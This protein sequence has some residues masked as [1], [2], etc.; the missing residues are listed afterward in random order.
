M[1]EYGEK[2][3]KA[4]RVQKMT[5]EELAKLEDDVLRQID[6]ARVD[7]KLDFI[8]FTHEDYLA[9][10]LDIIAEMFRKMGMI[11]LSSEFGGTADYSRWHIESERGSP[12]ESATSATSVGPAGEVMPE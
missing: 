1:P 7:S 8:D 2:R 3:L 5:P 4:Y 10:V 6:R 11:A 12:E 9:E